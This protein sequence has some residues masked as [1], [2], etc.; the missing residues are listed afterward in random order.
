MQF[1]EKEYKIN[2]SDV[3]LEIK[4]NQS[5]NRN[6]LHSLQLY[7]FMEN[8]LIFGPK[9]KVYYARY[10]I[11]ER[12]FLDIYS[13]WSSSSEFCFD[14]PLLLQDYKKVVT[15][16]LD[17]IADYT[18][19][20]S[21]EVEK[22]REFVSRINGGKY[23]SIYLETLN[24]LSNNDIVAQVFTNAELASYGSNNLYYLD[25]SPVDGYCFFLGIPN[26]KVLIYE[27]YRKMK[28]V[29]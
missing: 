19:E 14:T 27:L 11:A 23:L 6:D 15:N 17:K 24:S 10:S 29:Q 9:Y 13:L 7:A 12:V 21:N 25:S 16:T 3:K 4:D 20:K 18:K 22:F 1:Y 28:A 26:Y 5:T 2:L 8:E